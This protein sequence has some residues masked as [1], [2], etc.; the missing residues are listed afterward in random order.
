MSP[1]RRAPLVPLPHLLKSLIKTQGFEMR[2]VEFSL[3]QRWHLIVGS[4]IAAHT[5]PE[6]IRHRQLYLL[7]ENSVWLHQLLFLKAELLT[8]I[9]HSIGQEIL[10][11]IVLRVGIIPAPSCSPADIETE[12]APP[13]S[14]TL[15]RELLA[16]IDE[17]VLSLPHGILTEQLRALF[18]KSASVPH[19]ITSGRSVVERGFDPALLPHIRP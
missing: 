9:A 3:Q 10:S 5:Y 8:K 7:A 13:A 17:A 14:T 15:E 4:H 16:S 2:M 11:D 1:S 18:R 12:G 19:H 6:A